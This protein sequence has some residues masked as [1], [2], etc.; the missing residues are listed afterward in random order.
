MAVATAAQ[1]IANWLVTVTFPSLRT[2]ACPGTYLVYTA[3][4]LLSFV[5]VLRFVRETKGR[6]L[7]SMDELAGQ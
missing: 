6:T 5:F 7:E 3:F 1:W 4:A 2:G